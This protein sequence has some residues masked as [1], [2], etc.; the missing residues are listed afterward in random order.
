MSKDKNDDWTAEELQIYK[1]PVAALAYAVLKQWIVDGKPKS[2][3]TEVKKWKEI[4][5]EASECLR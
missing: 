2:Y 1:N 4:F 5:K 3:E